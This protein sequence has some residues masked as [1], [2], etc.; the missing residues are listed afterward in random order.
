MPLWTPPEDSWAGSTVFVIGGGLSLKSFDWLRLRGQR[1]IG[2]NSAY[3]HGPLVCSICFFSDRAWFEKFQTALEGYVRRGGFVVTHSPDFR[4]TEPS[5]VRTMP[6]QD[7][8][9]SRDALGYGAS[10]GCSALSL[11]LR[12]GA[13]RVILL[14][15]DLRLISALQPNWHTLSIEKANPEV[16]QRHIEGFEAAAHALPSVYPGVEVFNATEGSALTCFP[17]INLAEVLP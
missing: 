10:S 17:F 7:E 2:C 14:G 1:V 3:I 12:L 16:Y 6:R 5:W 11:A 15:M 4:D 8:G 13:A 9:L